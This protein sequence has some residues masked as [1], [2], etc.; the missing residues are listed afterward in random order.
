MNFYPR[1]LLALNVCQPQYVELERLLN[2][3]EE[4]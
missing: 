2:R 4:A 1:A 3:K